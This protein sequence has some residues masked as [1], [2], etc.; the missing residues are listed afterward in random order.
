MLKP[1]KKEAII[2]K[3]QKMINKKKKKIIFLLLFVTLMFFLLLLIF[4]SILNLNFFGLF[5][6]PIS[7]EIKDEC[8]LMMNNLIEQI[9]DEDVCKM[10]CINECE[11]RDKKI[12]DFDF[13]KK[14]DSCNY[15]YCYCR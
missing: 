4:L 12:F 14:E 10:M 2:G 6:K 9:K 8:S 13:L 5:N 7:F 3:K 15:C 1:V 11:L